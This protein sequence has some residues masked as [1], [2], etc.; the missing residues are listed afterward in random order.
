MDW[1]NL[2]Q[3]RD[4]WPLWTFEFHEMFRISWVAE[5]VM[6]L[7]AGLSFMEW[8]TC[9]KSGI[10]G[11][12]EQLNLSLGLLAEAWLLLFVLRQ[13]MAEVRGY[14][15]TRPLDPYILWESSRCQWVRRLGD[16]TP[17]CTARNLT[18]VLWPLR[19]YPVVILERWGNICG[20]ICS[21][22]SPCS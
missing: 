7:E 3:D 21:T 9:A 19:P 10:S 1:I 18:Q 5:Q 13:Q 6:V 15:A 20:L 12:A 16:N 4:Q 11:L 17:F 22:V 14:F 2:S 8:V